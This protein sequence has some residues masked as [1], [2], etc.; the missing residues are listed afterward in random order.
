MAEPLSIDLRR[1]VVDAVIGGMSRRRAAQHFKVGTSSAIRWVTQSLA[2]GDLAP[3]PQ[4][5]DHRSGAIEAQADFILSQLGGAGDATLAELQAALAAKGHWFSLSALSRFFA[6]R[7]ITR[8]KVSACGWTRTARYPETA[9]GLVCD[10][11]RSRPGKPRI[12]RR[13]LGFA[14][15]ETCLALGRLEAFLDRPAQT[16]HRGQ[17]RQR[18]NVGGKC[19]IERH[20]RQIGN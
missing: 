13:D 3:K 18:R 1:R 8:I 20:V 9:S 14:M 10:A 2:T 12:H 15:V 5:G 16:G 19:H 4:G 17:F 6:R 11:A 7:G